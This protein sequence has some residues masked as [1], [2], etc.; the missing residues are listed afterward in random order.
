MSHTTLKSG[1]AELIERLNRF[2]QGAPPSDT[3]YK[4]LQI[5]FSE[6][7]AQLVALLPIK[8]FTAEKA[9][10]VWKMDL[11]ETRKVLD[12]LASRAILV[13]VELDGKTTYTLPPPMAGFFEFSM[14]RLRGDINQK[15]LGELFYQ[16][17]N[18]EEEFVREL[19]V[20]G[21]TQL[22]RVFV[23]EPVLSGENALHVLSYERASEVIHTASHRGIGVCYCRHKMLHIGRN[24]DA[25]MDICM[26][27]NNI[28]QSLAR[29]GYARLVDVNEGMDLLQQAYEQNLVQ[30]GEN[31][32]QRVNFI[33][34]CC[35]CCCEAM[36]AARKFG[37]L[38]PVH[39]TNFLP[40]VDDAA[41]NGCGKCVNV[42]PVEAMTLVSANDPHHPKMKKAKVDE[43]TCLGCGVCVRTCSHT[44]LT[45]RPRPQRVITPLNSVHR[46]VM[47]A[48]ERGDFQN[49]LFDNRVLWNHRA[50]AAVLGV[51]LRLPPIKQAMA[52]QQVKSRYVEY[53]LTHIKI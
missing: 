7:E 10:R 45:L 43:D 35:G 47:M 17:L 16:Y 53:L 14:M 28:S 8:P 20:R 40:V 30:F 15:V 41:C 9:S 50:L 12:E 25:Q 18:V 6:R 26:T 46:T 3:L 21:E 51:I 1:Y 22:G 23:H 36:I 34:N 49:L 24:C 38:N 11:T 31:V 32:R 37:M 44:G 52:S 33:C 27:F 13:D 19:F 5:L 39:T 4:I 29:H 42:C 48:I 2:P